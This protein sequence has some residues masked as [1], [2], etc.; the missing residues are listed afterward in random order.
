MKKCICI[1]GHFYQP[2]R[3]NPWLETIE[4]QESAAP[5]HDWN[6]RISTEC[7]GPNGSSRILNGEQKIIDIVN[8]YEKISFNFG[9]TLLSWMESQDP[10][11]YQAILEADALSV[12]R[13]NGHGNAIAQIYNHIIMPLADTRDKETEIIWAIADFRRRFQRDPEGIWLSETAVDTE[14]LEICAKHGIRFTILAPRQAKAFRKKGERDFKEIRNADDLPVNRNYL[15]NLP[16]GN[17]ITLFFYNGQLAQQV[18]FDG[19]LNSGRLFADALL[20]AFDKK[21]NGPEIVHV[22]TDGETYGHHHRHGDMA[23]ASCIDFIEKTPDVEVVNYAQYNALFP[24]E[25]EVLIH[26]NTSWSCVHGVERWRSDCGCSDGG[27]PEYNQQWRAPLR[28]ALNWLKG[29]ADT[30]YLQ[31]LSGL[32]KDPWKA[33]NEYISVILQRNEGSVEQFI[34]ENF[35]TC[36]R[37]RDLPVILR[38]MEMERHV[39]LMFTSCAWFFDE[40]SRIET[41]QVLQYADRVIQIGEHEAHVQ[42]FDTFT[43]MLGEAK[44]NIPETGDAGKMYATEI[45]PREMTLSKVGM[46]HAVLSLFEEF[47]EEQEI[48]NYKTK[49]AFFERFEAGHHRL[50]LG[51]ISIFSKVSYNEIGFQFAALYLGQHHILGGYAEQMEEDS[52]EEMYLAIRDT[53]RRSD[54]AASIDIIHRYFQNNTFSFHD[55]FRDQQ[56]FVLGLILKNDLHLAGESYRKIYDDSHNIINLMHNEKIMIP[57]LLR[58]TLEVVINNELKNFFRQE[59]SNISRL[60]TLASEA[61]KWQV[62]LDRYTIGYVASQKVMGLVQQLSASESDSGLLDSI[63]RIMIRLRELDLGIPMWKIQNFYFK[64]GKQHI[65][66]KQFM[67]TLGEDAYTKWKQEYTAVGEQLNIRFE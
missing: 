59:R 62:P 34:S 14:T 43:R 28:N 17:A 57:D 25:Y 42:W 33:R 44:S 4:Y 46:H 9:P 55:L 63:S 54:V 48:Y 24:P 8:N 45:H 5:Y 36:D 47:P 13:R 61:V 6:V 49:S 3:E 31:L 19:L 29:Q 27:H 2:P 51:R 26:E 50:T 40:V 56:V 23:L 11:T 30:V 10:G 39:L 1:H 18:A 32:T 12:R 22:A 52:F 38:M 66:N 37:E 20:R 58:K 16:S 64:L 15:Y 65:G 67:E 7:Y 41:R 21:N 60:D 53:F 35:P